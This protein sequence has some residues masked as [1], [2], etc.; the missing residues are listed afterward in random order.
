MGFAG[1]WR[2][3]L[4]ASANRRLEHR[5]Q[6][7]AALPPTRVQGWTRAQRPPPEARTRLGLV[8]VWLS[9]DHPASSGPAGSFIAPG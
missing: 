5:R 6:L 4:R 2:R 3:E 8:T 1:K 7:E 9:G